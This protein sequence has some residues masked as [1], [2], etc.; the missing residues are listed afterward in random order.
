MYQTSMA[1]PLKSHHH[2]V[3]TLSDMM[4]DVVSL[5]LPVHN[6]VNTVWQQTCASPPCDVSTNGRPDNYDDIVTVWHD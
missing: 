6:D 1:A 3:V 2:A 4:F 5:D